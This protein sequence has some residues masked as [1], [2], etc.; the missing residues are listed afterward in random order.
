MSAEVALRPAVELRP[1]RPWLRQLGLLWLLWTIPGLI[2]ASQSWF[3]W[4]DPQVASS[5]TKVLLW[6]VP[7]WWYWI[8]GTPLILAMARRFPLA[9]GHLAAR[10]PLHLAANVGLATG[11]IAVVCYAGLLA[12]KSYFVNTPFPD[13]LLLMMQKNVHLELLTYF[14]VLAVGHAL[15]WQRRYQERALAAAQLETRLAQAQLEALK[16]QLHPHFLFNTLHAI[17]VLVRKQDTQGSIR[18]LTGL[19]DL[20][21][22]ALD[23]VGQQTVP[24]QLE[25][26]FV[27]RYLE[28]E[29]IRFQDRLQVEREVDAATLNDEVP[30]LVLQPIVE[31]AIRHG[32]SPRAEAGRLTISARHVD[33]R[34]RLEVRDDGV[35]LAPGF[36]P[37]FGLGNV[38][39]RLEQLYGDSFH[40]AVEPDPAGGTRVV[41]EL[42]RRHARD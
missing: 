25:L 17:A 35:G 18:M 3:L 37:G 32:L 24:L 14:G 7:P 23:S 41:L 42:P 9:R 19:S 39:A 5:F 1:A 2:S 33:H 26:D 4:N 22:L 10:L 28:I 38:R 20:L 21:R 40:F 11:H 36:R 31:N 6:Q 30:N 29:R 13:A 16:M 8:A 15:A 12:G 27:Q 34:L